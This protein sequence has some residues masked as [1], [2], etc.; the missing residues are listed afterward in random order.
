METIKINVGKSSI[1]TL[2]SLA[3]SGYLWSFSIDHKEIIAVSEERHAAPQGTLRGGESLSEK[4]KIQGIKPGKAKLI[5]IQK[6]SWEQ[7]KAAIS[8]LIFS[9]VVS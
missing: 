2:K 5:F 7:D 3:T 1:I 4:F 6:R 8:T 9:V